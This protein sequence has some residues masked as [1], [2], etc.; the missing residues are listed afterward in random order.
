MAARLQYMTYIRP[1]LKK[2][3]TLILSL[4]V[5]CF[6]FSCKH[7]NRH[8]KNL[9]ETGFSYD[10]F[11][12]QLD[13]LIPLA[14]TTNPKKIRD[15]A[16]DMRFAYF[17]ND[18]YPI[19]LSHG[20]KP[21]KIVDSVIK[22]LEDMRWD[23]LD[24]EHYGLA[25]INKLKER[26]GKKETTLADAIAFDTTLT[27]AYLSAAKDLLVGRVIPKTV[28]SLWY[29]ANDSSW[30]APII[31]NDV[32][33]KYVSLNVFR[34]NVPTYKLLRD[35]YKHI[36]MLA[37]D[38]DYITAVNTFKTLDTYND[39]AAQSVIRTL[40]MQAAPWITTTPDDTIS[41]WKQMIMA[42]QDFAGIKP[43][44]K[45][46]STTSRFFSTPPDSLLP[47]LAAN[48]ERIRWMQQDF[49]NMYI[50]VNVPLMQLFFRLNNTNAMHMRVVVGK[51]S[52]Q[53]PSLY[54]KM[55]NVVLN[56][57]WGVPST[58]LKQDV[59]PGIQK[60]GADYMRKKGLKAYDRKG[61]VVNVKNINSG[62]YKNYTYKQPPG[63]DNALGYVKFNL[64]NPWDIYLHDTPHRDDFG[65]RD[66]AL[67]SGCIRLHH[68]QEMAIFIL[69]EIEKKQFS[70]EK[71]DSIIET[72]KTQWR[73]LSNKI[74]VHIAYLTAFEDTTGTHI[75]FVRD[76]YHRDGKLMASLTGN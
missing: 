54:A 17:Q 65:K 34:S 41:E 38:S 63:D 2:G 49:G 71:L 42:Y 5:L 12:E 73:V 30:N 40:V 19:W 21:D 50:L 47:K 18:Y 45:I 44:G 60:N 39:S 7:K 66:R 32:Q 58:I 33:S 28:D 69:S 43:T 48:M 76:V 24:P 55:S 35:E 46:D 51:P 25:N 11:T 67:S 57:Q 64:P 27:R 61:N 8:K 14:D 9:I 23:G 1:G 70:Q 10:E 4:S 15:V 26:L 59:L 6:S 29:H 22:D 72:H 13:K 37:A 36:T 3:I 20:Y 62:N 31:L 16:T 56:P 75:N 74:P 53:T 52:R 68:P